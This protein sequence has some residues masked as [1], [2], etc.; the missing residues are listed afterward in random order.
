[1]KF[2]GC[3][4]FANPSLHIELFRTIIFR[5]T[6]DQINKTELPDKKKVIGFLLHMGAQKV[7][8]ARQKYWC[9][10]KHPETTSKHLIIGV[11]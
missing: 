4:K 7:S 1:M 10:L 6:D 11:I 9:F 2:A 5:M 8:L 3:T